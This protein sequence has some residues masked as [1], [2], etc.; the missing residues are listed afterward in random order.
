MLAVSSYLDTADFSASTFYHQKSLYYCFINL[1]MI[2]ADDKRLLEDD[3]RFFLT[4]D[5]DKDERLSK[6]EFHAFQNPESFPHMHTALIE[7]ILFFR[8]YIALGRKNVRVT[9]EFVHAFYRTDTSF[10][11]IT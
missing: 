6:S 3:W 11:N 8:I 9:T 5:E 1:Q 10:N 7:V 2:D 4:A